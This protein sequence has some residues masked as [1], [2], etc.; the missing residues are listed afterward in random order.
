MNNWKYQVDFEQRLTNPRTLRRASQ[1]LE[2]IKE[3]LHER[4][5]NNVFRVDIVNYRDKRLR[6]HKPSTVRVDLGW[7]KA[8]WDWLMER[9]LVD[10]NPFRDVKKPRVEPPARRWLKPEIVAKLRE[11]PPDNLK[12]AMEIF[13]FTP[14]T[15][16]DI[17]RLKKDDFDWKDEVVRY[18]RGKTGKEIIVPVP[19]CLLNFIATLPDGPLYPD[20]YDHTDGMTL[21]SQRFKRHCER[22]FG[23]NF[24]AHSLRHTY[25]SEAI[26]NGVDIR[27]LKEIMGHSDINTTAR[28]L[29][30]INVESVRKFVNQI[31]AT[32]SLSAEIART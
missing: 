16:N 27:T 10:H 25:G 21:L 15:C 20:L 29:T 31:P 9:E 32:A 14:L 3:F 22:L 30:P 19:E 28:Y 12:I 23:K 24:G 6:T 8:F 1:A 2:S 13:A 5:P 11:N 17:A 26:N 18:R 7:G 4:E